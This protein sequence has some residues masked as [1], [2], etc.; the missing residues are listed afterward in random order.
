M[1]IVLFFLLFHLS[2]FANCVTDTSFHCVKFIRAYDGDTVKVNI[3]GV[4]PLIGKRINIRVKGIDTPEIKAPKTVEGKC[5]KKKARIAQKLVNSLMKNAKKIEIKNIERDKYFRILADIYYDNNL[6]SKTLLK[7]KL[8]YEY[9][10]GKKP[11]INWC[12]F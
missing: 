7:N 8:A 5:E 12:S 11:K 9:H 6:L 4:H 2:L 1:K 10:G 3:Q